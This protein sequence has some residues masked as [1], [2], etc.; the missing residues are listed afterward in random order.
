MEAIQNQVKELM[1]NQHHILEAIKYLKE[2]VEE[3]NH[4]NDRLKE[5]Q[6]M[7]E[8]QALIEE[9]I[10][11]NSDDIQIIKRSKEEANTAL[12]SIDVQIA[13]IQKELEAMTK[14]TKNKEKM[15]KKDKLQQ[16]NDNVDNKFNDDM[17][18]VEKCNL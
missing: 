10:V 3:D 1:V 5:M 12:R 9:V 18:N 2:K 17:E 15:E 11:K 16:S 14:K 13:R 7:I 8:S 6:D 4:G